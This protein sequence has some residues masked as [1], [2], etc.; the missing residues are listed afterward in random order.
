MRQSL[1]PIH[2]LPVHIKGHQDD[3]ASFILEEAPLEVQCN[4]EMD[5]LS[6]AFLKNRQGSLEATS[7]S[8]SLP[9]QKS[10]LRVE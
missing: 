6:K 2:I 7:E 3:D 10:F 4:I 5:T 8:R 1:H 9:V